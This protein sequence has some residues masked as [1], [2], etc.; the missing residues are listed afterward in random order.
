MERQLVFVFGTLKQGFP[1]FGTNAGQRLPGEFVTVQAHPL[2]LVGDRHSPWM[3]ASPGQGLAVHGQVFGVDESTLARMDLLE[4]TGEPDG[5][6]R[7]MIQVR[8]T[9]APGAALEVWAY[10][11]DPGQ[12][13]PQDIRLGPL[14]EYTLAH[15]ALY[16]SRPLA[17]PTPRRWYG[18]LPPAE[19]APRRRG[20]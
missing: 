17:A 5:Y 8:D 6:R 1:N 7:V 4:R 18:H 20:G 3:L 9:Q 19:P 10:L 15:A 16:R 14:A 12:L 11:K 13:Q 2:Y